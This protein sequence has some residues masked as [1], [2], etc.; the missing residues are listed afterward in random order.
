MCAAQANVYGLKRSEIVLLRPLSLVSTVTGVGV[1]FVFKSLNT[2]SKHPNQSSGAQTQT[3]IHAVECVLTSL[4]DTGGAG[5]C[6]RFLQHLCGIPTMISL[7]QAL[8]PTHGPPQ[9]LHCATQ[10]SPVTGPIPWTAGGSG[11]ADQ[12]AALFL[13]LFVLK[14]KAATG[15]GAV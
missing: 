11:G 3:V 13:G 9:S 4:G 2:H 7:Q 8:N 10:V 14:C 5:I 6:A 12:I 1:Y 15:G